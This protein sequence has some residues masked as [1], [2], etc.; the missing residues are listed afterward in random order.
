VPRTRSRACSVGST[1][2]SHHEYAGHPAFSHAMVLTV[3]SALSPATNSSCH[4]HQRI[5]LVQARSGR[6]TSTNLASATDARTT[7]LHRTLQHRSSARRSIAHGSGSIQNPPC[8]HARARRCRVHRIPPRVNDDGQRPSV[9]R[10]GGGYGFES[11]PAKTEIFLRRG[12]DRELPG[13]PVG[14]IS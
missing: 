12:L 9:G 7:R 14:Q 8:H 1:R 2:V 5:W 4:R 13:E 11:G 3:Y 6:R 10:D